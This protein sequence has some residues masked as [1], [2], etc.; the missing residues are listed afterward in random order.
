MLQFKNDFAGSVLNNS[1]GKAEQSYWWT[2]PK[3]GLP[4][5]CR[6][7]YVIDDMVIDLKTT[8]EGGA[9]PDVFTR[10]IVNFKYHLHLFGSKRHLF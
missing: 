10:T 8:G 7:D 5:K 1:S 3:T 6:C 2:H 9:S 4:C